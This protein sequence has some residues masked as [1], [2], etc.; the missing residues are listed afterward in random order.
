LE[1]RQPYWG[2]AGSAA[3]HGALLALILLGFAS[4]RKFADSPEAIAIE[5]VS[6]SEL[7]QIAN[8]EKNASARAAATAPRSAH[9]RRTNA[10]AA[11]RAAP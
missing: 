5:T 1:E 8:G 3:L 6:L 10:S 11:A 4:A 7:N 2:F 9:I